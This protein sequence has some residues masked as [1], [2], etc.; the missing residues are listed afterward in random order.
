VNHLSKV[1]VGYTESIHGFMICNKVAYIRKYA[2]NYEDQTHN[3]LD[4]RKTQ[5]KVHIDIQ[6]RDI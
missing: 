3:L 5:Y 1:K 2:H 6:P 4:K